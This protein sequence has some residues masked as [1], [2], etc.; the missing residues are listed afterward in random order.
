MLNFY[1]EFQIIMACS[2]SIK[3]VL[4]TMTADITKLKKDQEYVKKN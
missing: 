4:D 2:G 3:H 1:Q